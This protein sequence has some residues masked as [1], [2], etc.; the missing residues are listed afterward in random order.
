M[1]IVSGIFIVA[2][3][4]KNRD[5]SRRNKALAVQVEDHVADRKELDRKTEENLALYDQLEQARQELEAERVK[6]VPKQE[7][8]EA[9][10]IHV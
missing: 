6:N 1:L 3:I 4:R 9:G 5:I 7:R 2:I 8:A 10:K